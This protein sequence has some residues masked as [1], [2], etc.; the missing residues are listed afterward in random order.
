VWTEL[1]PFDS[2]PQLLNPPGGYLQNAND[3]FHYTNLAAVLD[4]ARWPDYFPRPELGLRSQLALRLVTHQPKV[5]LDDV[6]RLKHD[7]RML[8]AE[9]LRND[10]VAALRSADLTVEL[11]A[12]AALVERWD[13]TVSPESRGGELFETWFRFYMGQDS[14]NRGSFDE[15]WA[16]AF[17]VPW[18]PAEPTATPRGIANPERAV[19]AF[20]QAVESMKTDFGRWDVAWGE[21]HRMR[22]GDLDLPVGGCDGQLGCFRVL[23]FRPSADTLWV[24]NRGDAWILAVEFGRNGPRAYSILAYGQSDDPA[25]PQ[26]ADQAPLFA[27]GELKRV[28]FTER[29]IARD[30]VRR[31]RPGQ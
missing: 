3:P 25:S 20:G 4:P 2:L 5:S 29:A 19:A 17:Q 16:R 26:F 28:A 7:L 31:Y 22:R 27:R 11:R 18:S 12:A 21:V 9:R 15:R 6:I 24:A 13:G 23:Q 30:L 14:T 1:W 8:L 10:L